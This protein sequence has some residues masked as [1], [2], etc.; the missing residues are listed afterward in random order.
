MDRGRGVYNVGSSVEVSLR[1][2]IARFEDIAGRRL[3]VREHG[4]AHGDPGRTSADTRIE[5]DLGWRAGTSFE[6]GA[7]AQWKWT[8]ESH[9]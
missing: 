1:D 7:R 8:L 3:D 9:R 2:A 4:R 6:D 5:G